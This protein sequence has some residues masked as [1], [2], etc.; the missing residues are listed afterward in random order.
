MLEAN[1]IIPAAKQVISK[2]ENIIDRLK[3]IEETRH[4]SPIHSIFK[5]VKNKDENDDFSGNPQ[6]PK[7]STRNEER[8]GLNESKS[9][10][11]ILDYLEV[12]LG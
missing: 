12:K 8:I 2:E 4:V 10:K 7:F 3:F 6:I 5:I 11:Q 9:F 1:I